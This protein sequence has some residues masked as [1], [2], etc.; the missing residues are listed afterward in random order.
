MLTKAVD[1]IDPSLGGF[2]LD[3]SVVCLL[4]LDL[5]DDTQSAVCFHDEVRHVARRQTLFSIGDKETQTIILNP[6]PHP[7]M[8]IEQEGGALLPFF[9][10]CNHCVQVAARHG[11]NWLGCM[12]I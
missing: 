1:C 9:R 4:A 8:A 2:S 3:I 7:G 10:V 5:H 6:L 12:E 11:V